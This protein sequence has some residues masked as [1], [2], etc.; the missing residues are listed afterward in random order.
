M[1][2][3]L[4]KLR[5]LIEATE[6]PLQLSSL[7][8]A[9]YV[10]FVSSVPLPT[11]Q[12][13]E[14][15][16][17]FVSHAHSWYKHLPFDPPGVPFHFFID[18][19][20]GC[21]FA[22]TEEGRGDILE[23]EQRG[24]HYSA[25]PTKEQRARF[26]YLAFSCDAGTKVTRLG[27]GPIVISRDKIACI[28]GDDATLCV[29]PPEILKAGEVRLT[30][31]IHTTTQSFHWWDR[32]TREEFDRVE[33]PKESGGQATLDGIFA[34]CRELREPGSGHPFLDALSEYG[35]IDPL[36]H[37]LL[38]PEQ[39][40]QQREMVKAMDRVCDLVAGRPRPT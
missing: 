17:D 30:A 38:V 26:G 9:Q 34:R 20:A 2:V 12:Q 7:T 31:F 37:N 15:F 40:R 5:K 10:D 33:W 24:F 27:E 1:S 28:P 11:Q 16:A 29:V 4:D 19:Y 35:P 36:L 14:D 3:N 39:K 25:I 32:R 18:K 6:K 21:D 13:K 23:R 8:L 22:L